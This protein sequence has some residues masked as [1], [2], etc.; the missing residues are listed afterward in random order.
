[1]IYLGSL[2]CLV[3][4][5]DKIGKKVKG[6][7]ANSDRQIFETGVFSAF[8]FVLFHEKCEKN[9]METLWID[10]RCLKRERILSLF[11]F[12]NCHPFRFFI[13]GFWQ[14]TLVY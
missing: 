13:F 11:F 2:G 3:E 7:L 12:F 1:M 4:V 5:L 6:Y 8:F 14:K 10:S 9:K